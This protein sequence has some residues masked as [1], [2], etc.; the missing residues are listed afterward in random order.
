MRFLL[1]M[2][3]WG[4][5]ALLVFPLDRGG[6]AARPDS[7]SPVQAWYAVSEAVGDLSAIC[8]RKPEVCAIGRQAIQTVGERARDGARMAFE[9][10]DREFGDADRESV[11]GSIKPKP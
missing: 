10:L 8:V 7:V 6:E 2:A 9:A 1:R 3:F 4:A 11:T 5:L